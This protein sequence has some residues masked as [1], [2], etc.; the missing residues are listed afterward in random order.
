MNDRRV[1]ITGMGIVSSLGTTL[2]AHW[3]ALLAKSTGIGQVRGEPN[4]LP[5]RYAGRVESY[6]LPPNTPDAVLKQERFMSPSSRFALGAVSDAVAH[7]GLDLLQ[8]RPERKA[9]YIGTGDYS[10]VGLPDYYPALREAGATEGVPIDCEKLN[11]ATLH[12]VNPFVLLEWLT[13]NLV[14][15]VSLLYKAQGPNTTLSSQSPCGAQTLELATRTLLRG[16]ADLA[17]VVGSCAWSNPIPLFE[18]DTLGLLS[19]CHD[20]PSSFRPFDRRR[21]GFIAG[22]GA[23]ALILERLEFARERKAKLLGTICG[24]GSFTQVSAT[25]GL[26]VP[27]ESCVKAMAAA[28]REAEIEPKDLAFISPHGNGTR[29]GDRSEL[30]AT[31]EILKTERPSVPVCGLKPYTGHMGAASDVAE[32]ALGLTALGKGLVPATLNFRRADKGFEDIDVV[33]DHRPTTGRYFLS[34][35]QGFGGQSLAVVVSV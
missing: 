6:E 28:L 23:A 11:Q 13:N 16:D 21:D 1:A 9:L 29:K 3:Q 14:A 32:I 7:S 35:S 27:V 12:T 20:G 26:G 30:V 24:F 15:F 8:I 33:A 19:H 31:R 25:G 2:D 5:L 34:M 10:K 4:P 18:L 22:D 17:I